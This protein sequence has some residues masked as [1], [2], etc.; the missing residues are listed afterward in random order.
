MRDSTLTRTL[1]TVLVEID[2][3][4]DVELI[5]RFLASNDGSAFELLL[6]R[7]ADLVFNVLSIDPS[8]GS[9]RRGGCVSDNFFSPCTAGEKLDEMRITG[10]L[11]LSS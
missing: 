2:R 4:S 10:C 3:T 7:H 1:S 8:R 5:R 9:S 6:R 11:A